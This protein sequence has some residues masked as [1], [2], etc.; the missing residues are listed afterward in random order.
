M[1]FK[2]SARC[3]CCVGVSMQGPRGKKRYPGR[4]PS[5]PMVR[6]ESARELLSVLIKKGA[7]N[8]AGRMQVAC[9]RMEEIN[10]V[11]RF[12]VMT[13]TAP[14]DGTHIVLAENAKG[15][16]YDRLCSRK[17]RCQ[18]RILLVTACLIA[19]VIS[20]WSNYSSVADAKLRGDF[21]VNP[22]TQM[23]FTNR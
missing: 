16:E 17:G 1:K 11:K 2:I 3:A 15:S 21:P 18:M 6:L 10:S 4:R 7:V 13:S 22:A 5:L 23:S 14:I 9:R 20:A 12:F 8:R 19:L